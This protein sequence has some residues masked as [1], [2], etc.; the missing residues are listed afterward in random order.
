MSK[1]G[2]IIFIV[3][4]IFI[5]AAVVIGVTFG[6][7]KIQ[8]IPQVTLPGSFPVASSSVG[9]DVSGSGGAILPS[10]ETSGEIEA[11][12]SDLNRLIQLTKGPVIDYWIASTTVLGKSSTTT[13]SLLRSTVFYLTPGGDIVQ[14]YDAGKEDTYFSFGLSPLKLIQSPS[15]QYIAI[16]LQTKRIALFD[17]TRRAFEL[18][19]EG[20]VSAT[21]SSDGNKLAYLQAD[22][23]GKQ[24][25]Y[26]RDLTSL[27][28]TITKVFSL[29]IDDVSL[30]WPAGNNIY[31]IPPQSA[32]AVGEIWYFN[33]A[34]KTLNQFVSGSGVGMVVSQQAPYALLFKNTS[35]NNIATSLVNI[36]TGISTSL[37]VDT[38]A[39]K[40]VFSFDSADA[41]CAAPQ[42]KS[43]NIVSQLPD[44]YNNMS[45]FTNDYLY[46][47]SADVGYQAQTLL[48]TTQVPF[49]AKDLRS[50]AQQV[51]FVNR[52][53]DSLYVF[54][55][56]P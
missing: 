54:D 5:L 44:D 47:L 21:F 48:G 11:E 53:D 13:P 25:L 32:D 23:S 18:L 28:K 38:L 20:V 30:S 34:Q 46:R 43:R 35:N 14:V 12:P 3:A 16:T 15:G 39:S 52:L 27:K 8:T 22:S 26:I 42:V 7:R 24:S 33:T 29:F 6:L 50:R 2:K 10:G 37:G 1:K 40:C 41:L 55:Y 49:D 4:I 31:L 56:K 36:K 45:L 51:F 17:V 9:G 19:P